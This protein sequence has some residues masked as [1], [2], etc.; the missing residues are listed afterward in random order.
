MN[1][2]TGRKI[3]IVTGSALG[4]GYE[5]TRQLIDQGWFVAGIDFNTERQAELSKSFGKDEY[6]AF[7]GDVSDESFVRNSIAAIRRIGH[8]DLL[9]NNAGQPSFKAPT[10][11]EAADVD[12][13]LK[14][15]RGMILW[16]VETLKA[17]G[18]ADLKIANVM[19]TAATRGNA[20]ESVYCATKWGEKG[21]T[22]SLKAA[23]KGSSVKI[24]G[25]YPGGIDTDFYRDSHDYVSEEKQHTFMSPAELAKVILFNLVNDADLT[26]SD[27]LIERNYR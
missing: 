6:R 1:T 23:Y 8:I 16:S 5:L 21:Y 12:K 18:E 17:D 19:S 20:N 22:N 25:V 13:C 4:L 27:I 9:I 14:G 10:A 7:V 15:L 24:V 11:Y 2:A 26:V 3:A